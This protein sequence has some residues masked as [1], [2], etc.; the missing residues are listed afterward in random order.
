MFNKQAYLLLSKKGEMWDRHFSV[1]TNKKHCVLNGDIVH[2]STALRQDLWLELNS[3]SF[4]PL[5]SWFVRSLYLTVQ[6][7]FIF[8]R[9]FQRDYRNICNLFVE[10][11]YMHLKSE[12]LNHNSKKLYSTQSTAFASEVLLHGRTM[13]P[14]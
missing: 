9:Y 5:V 13:S 3:F 4:S 1:K 7:L 14:F 12:C 2:C 6:T 10:L 11:N 8:T